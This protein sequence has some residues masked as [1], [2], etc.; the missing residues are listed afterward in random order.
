MKTS[1]LVTM[2]G[3]A[4]AATTAV[5]ILRS[6]PG[7]GRDLSQPPEAAEAIA[8]EA[9]AH[10]AYAAHLAANNHAVGGGKSFARNARV[11]F[12]GQKGIKNGIGNAVTDLVRV[13]L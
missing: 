5:V 12:L 13:P 4:I 10:A 3:T 1:H 11:R 8:A 2:L 6:A 9:T 7:L